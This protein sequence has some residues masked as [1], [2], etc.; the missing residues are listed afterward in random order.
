MPALTLDLT[1]TQ[2]A[3]QGMPVGPAVR[4]PLTANSLA[5]GQPVQY[6]GRIKGGPRFGLIGTVVDTHLSQA[7]VDMGPH[8][9]WRIPYYLLSVPQALLGECDVVQVA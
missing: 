8:G 9:R 2:I 6:H 5:P 7:V 3:M 1:S 4:R